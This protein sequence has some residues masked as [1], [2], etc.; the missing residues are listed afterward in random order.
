[1]AVK[2]CLRDICVVFIYLIAL[3]FNQAYKWISK[4][5][6][7]LFHRRGS[8]KSDDGILN[9]RNFELQVPCTISFSKLREISKESFRKRSG[10]PGERKPSFGEGLEEKNL[11]DTWIPE[12]AETTSCWRRRREFPERRGRESF[13]SGGEIFWK[14]RSWEVEEESF[15]TRR[16]PRDTKGIECL[17]RAKTPLSLS[18]IRENIVKLSLP[19]FIREKGKMLLDGEQG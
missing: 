16:I 1:M 14:T 10:D 17:I 13:F 6:C 3:R 2:V 9:S 15:S 4:N 8:M 19:L 11:G 12:E 18:D 7:K 5:F